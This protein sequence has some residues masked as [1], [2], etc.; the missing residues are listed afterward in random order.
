ML[1][2][3]EE[4]SEGV[5]K[6]S[7][8]GK[9][10]FVR[11][12]DGWAFLAD[13]AEFLADLPADPL[14][15]LGDLPKQYAF[16]VRLIA[17]NAPQQQREALVE[18]LKAHAA[19]E[20]N[21]RPAESD[22]EYALR[23]QI[24]E[25]LIDVWE[26]LVNNLQEVTLGFALDPEHQKS[27]L[28]LSLTG[29]EGSPSSPIAQASASLK[30]TQSQFAGFRLPEATLS[31]N[32]AG[33]MPPFKSEL[34]EQIIQ[35][36][37]R[38]AIADI[39]KKEHNP[40]K[41]ETAK[42]LVEQ[43]TALLFDTLK[44]GRA[45]GGLAVLLKPDAV[46]ILTGGYVANDGRLEELL[47]TLY[48]AAKADNPAVADWVKFN[49][50]QCQG[51]QLHTLSLP[52]PPDAKDREKVVSLVGE[53]LEIVVGTGKD[54][55][56]V[57]AGRQPLKTLKQVI[58]SSAVSTAK[59]LTPVSFSLDV[60]QLAEFLAAEAKERDRPLA[61]R[62]AEELKKS[63]ETDHILLTLQ[64]I[65]HG[66]KYRLEMESGVQR[67]LC[68]WILDRMLQHEHPGQR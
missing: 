2:V 37:R 28:E 30:E 66:V 35:T 3:L 18:Q 32:W 21:K 45:D 52:I 9:T 58:E 34:L 23:K 49:A 11:V 48:R 24:S 53:T 56:Y 44:S 14:Q 6:I 4:T 64:S 31:G 47:Q 67:L 61:R 33:K 46:T 15:M 57:A 38:H 68:R 22:E 50:D 51:V 1:G 13:H 27:Y 63:P 19:R 10:T 20:M 54:C 25:K 16:A 40:D 39:E 26:K 17:A 5:Y 60:R 65:P 62:I 43:V 8:D 36:V 29:K 12:T 59:I 42:K 55:I 41:A 7:K